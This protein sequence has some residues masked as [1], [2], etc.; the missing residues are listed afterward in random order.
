M[1]AGC[2]STP[3]RGGSAMQEPGGALTRLRLCIRQKNLP[4]TQQA[5]TTV[6][7]LFVGAYHGTEASPE[8]GHCPSAGFASRENRQKRCNP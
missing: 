4:S 3:L 6:Q 7:A 2:T 1:E 8:G 5:Q